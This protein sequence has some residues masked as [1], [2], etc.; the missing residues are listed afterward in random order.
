MVQITVYTSANMGDLIKQN[1]LV[2][3]YRI[4]ADNPQ[5]KCRNYRFKMEIP[6]YIHSRIKIYQTKKTKNEVYNPRSLKE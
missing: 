6:H 1:M 3:N 5:N 2:I 4:C